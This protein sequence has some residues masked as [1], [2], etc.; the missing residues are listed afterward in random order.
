MAVD[1]IARGMAGSN[2]GPS[3]QNSGGGSSDVELI[4]IA[5][6]SGSVAYEFLG[7][8]TEGAG[9]LRITSLSALDT[10]GTLLGNKKVIGIVCDTG[11]NADLCGAKVNVSVSG[12]PPIVDI[13]MLNDDIELR[14]AS[15][16]LQLYAFGY[17]AKPSTV[18]I[19]AMCI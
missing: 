13:Q 19:Y 14:N 10:L 5:S 12:F 15:N 11:G 1:I 6:V 17:G 4:K 16:G 3:D 2:A 9:V 7:E 18:D 8:S